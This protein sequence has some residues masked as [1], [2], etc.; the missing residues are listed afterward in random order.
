MRATNA[1][2]RDKLEIISRPLS[3][4][5]LLTMNVGSDEFF[6]RLS[7]IHDPFDDADDVHDAGQSKAA[8][9]GYQEHDKAFFLI[10]EHELVNPQTAYDYAKN[11][12]NDLFVGAGLFPILDRRLAVERGWRL[13]RF[14]TWLK[15]RLI[16][17]LHWPLRSNDR[18]GGLAVQTSLRKVG[19]LS[20]ALSTEDCHFLLS[21]GRPSEPAALVL[22]VG[23]HEIFV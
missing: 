18:Q 10:P 15:R 2:G 11:S 19:I 23:S 13:D 7:E 22:N 8:K 17:R 21:F 14:I 3:E 1:Y 12:G 6:I 4:P 16:V 20:A 5:A 9:N